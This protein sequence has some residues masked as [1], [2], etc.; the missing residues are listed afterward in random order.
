MKGNDASGP[1]DWLMISNSSSLFDK[2]RCQWNALPSAMHRVNGESVTTES[3]C[4][5]TEYNRVHDFYIQVHT[6]IHTCTPPPQLCKI[7]HMKTIKT[8]N[9]NIVT[10]WEIMGN[11]VP[12]STFHFFPPNFLQ[13]WIAW[14]SEENVFY[15]SKLYL[16]WMHRLLKFSRAE[17]IQYILIQKKNTFVNLHQDFICLVKILMY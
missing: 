8:L 6:L 17:M 11:T 9:Q 7:K 14:I 4:T 2:R 12:L 16:R 13:S 5:I 3:A 10:E 15:N 1:G